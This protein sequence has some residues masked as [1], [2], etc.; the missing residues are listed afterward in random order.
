MR[1]GLRLALFAC[2][3]IVSLAVAGTAMAAFTPRLT[4]NQATTGPPATSNTLI[5]IAI[6]KDDA[7]TLKTTIYAPLGYTSTLNQP[8]GTQVGTVKATA[9]AKAISP[10][11]ILP[12]EG[13]IKTDNP[14]NYTAIPASVACAGAAPHTAV[15]LLVL[16]AAGQTLTVPAYV[17]TITAGPE[18]AFASAKI[19]I[20]LPSPDIPVASGGATFGAKVLEANLF[21]TNVFTAPTA[22]G[23]YVWSA[24]FTPYNVGAGTPNPAGTVESRAIVILPTQIT[25]SAKVKNKKKHQISVTGAVTENLVGISGQAIVLVVGKKPDGKGS[26]FTSKSGAGGTFG[27]LLTLK[28]GTYY[29]TVGVIVA[30]RDATSTECAGPS[31]APAGCVSATVAGFTTISRTIKIKV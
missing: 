18:A 27:G 8:A 9:Q 30:D 11:A 22:A 12:L 24:V 31:K 3:S 20:C 19:T 2:A 6:P 21:L 5:K 15:F 23:K 17:D 10:D 14:A 16:T 13:V 26:P 29:L 28:K 1:T 7:A 25:I 4:V